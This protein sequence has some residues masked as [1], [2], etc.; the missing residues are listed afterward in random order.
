M[1]RY[2]NTA[3]LNILQES[4]KHLPKTTLNTSAKPYWCPELKH[5]HAQARHFR[6]IWLQT[7]RPRGCD[8]MSYVEYKCAKSSFR[9][10]QR[11][12]IEN[13]ENNVF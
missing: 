9:R 2:S 1:L 11:Q 7:G 3:L 13:H 10:P 5:A 6:Y 4:E 8:D 12:C